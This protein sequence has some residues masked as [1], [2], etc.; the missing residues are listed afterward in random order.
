MTSSLQRITTEYIDLEDRIRLSG[1]AE[2][3]ELVV[4]WLHQRLLKRLLPVLLQWLE[5]Q[6][7]ETPR[8]EA[9]QSFAQQA[10][11]SELSPQEPI[12]PNTDSTT[13]LA[14]SVDITSSEQMVSLVFRGSDQQS[15]SLI[16][17][18]QPLR[19]WLGIVYE[20]YVK[21]EWALDVWPAWLREN[22][23]ASS[24]HTAVLH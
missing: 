16:L 9:L 24:Q 18:A 15:A 17:A 10:A 13:W 2:N 4:I 23:L 3:A 14:M 21:A 7:I 12:Q 1:E 8:A 6:T 20:T 5:R 22:R 11:L 19:Q